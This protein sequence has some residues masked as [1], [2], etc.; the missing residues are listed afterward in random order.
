MS[1]SFWLYRWMD[2]F[3]IKSE[4]RLDRAL[5]KQR[6]LARLTEI[7]NEDS[8]KPL[9]PHWGTGNA[10]VAG[11]GADLS[12]HM[13]CCHAVCQT[14]QVDELFGRVLH[15]FDEIVVSGPP[16]DDYAEALEHADSNTLTN[17]REHM[18][19]L[20][21][22]RKIGATPMVTFARKPPPCTVHYMQHAE[23]AGVLE[24]VDHGRRLIN[25]LA[26]SGQLVQLRAHEDHWHYTFN[27]PILEHT[28][29]GTIGPASDGSEPTIA[30]VAAAV[31][32]EFA[33]ALVSDVM[34][35][36]H[37]NLPLGP[38]MKMHSNALQS[39]P[40]VVTPDD[41]A[42][43]LQLP[44]LSKLPIKEVV[45]IRKHERDA[46]ERFQNALLKAIR[47]R[48]DAGEDDSSAMAREIKSEVIDPALD[49]IGQRLRSA[50]SILGKKG[51]V[52]VSSGVA[53]A[54]AGLLS[55]VPLIASLGIAAAGTTVPAAHKYFD[56]KGAVTLSDMYFLWCLEKRAHK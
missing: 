36:K 6:S 37:H 39:S 28:Q 51:A 49:D 48:I 22:L 16:P 29:W 4:R 44:I 13:D 43:D 19:A 20:L 14:R 17:L 34:A 25:D 7:A 54:S 11:R 9:I 23:E 42:F 2:E 1:E 41:V 52:S 3:G 38:F 27:H 8:N 21:Y 26:K 12:G 40:T 18:K 55:G 30:D 24:V 45:S 15:Y 32:V 5:G 50:R 35:A 53:V 10:I 47:E 31:Y 33:A 46:F 56:D